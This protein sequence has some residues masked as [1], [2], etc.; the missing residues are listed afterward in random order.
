MKKNIEYFKKHVEFLKNKGT[1]PIIH[2][3]EGLSSS[4]EVFIEG[5]KFLNFSSNNYLGL[6]NDERIKKVV[7]DGIKKYG[8]GSGST[9]LLAGTLD[10]QIEFEKALAEFFGKDDSIT[11]SS[12]FLANVGVIRM[13]IDPFPYPQLFKGEDGIIISD[14]LNH[15][16]IVDGVR[17]AKAERFIYK[18]N[19]VEDLEKILKKNKNKKKLILTDGVFS[20]DGDVAKLK[21]I[22]EL[23]K[24]Y[25]ALV[26]VDDSHGL[27]VLGPKGEGA[28]HYL[29]VDK[30]I[31]VIMGSFTK[32]FGS[33][34]GFVVADKTTSDYLRVTARSYI[35]SDPI[36]PSVVAGLIEA[37]KII[38][39]GSELR[40]TTLSNA[41][42]LRK[43]LKSLGFTVLGNETCI[44]PLLIGSDEKAR[45]FSDELYK[46]YILAPCIRVP[47]VIEGK[48]RIRFSI[49][50]T[51]KKEQ[52]DILLEICKKV[53]RLINI[54]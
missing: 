52:I 40:E 39:E 10:V 29:G 50:V 11:F 46:N 54:I 12:G 4:P 53:G 31:D 13:L 7:V 18:H 1:Y 9:R 8:V 41:D 27:G 35:F 21:E 19:D 26:M 20:M 43:N 25:D 23:S 32:A 3:V 5:K 22:A 14:E 16:S 2:E 24:I 17:L 51:H 48:E 42:Y 45:H 34:G 30:D 15:A 28:A 44:V 38:R 47:A 6:A 33:I 49:M 36:I 37:L